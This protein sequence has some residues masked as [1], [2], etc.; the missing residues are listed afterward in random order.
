M[1]SKSSRNDSDISRLYKLKKGNNV[2]TDAVS[3]GTELRFGQPSPKSQT[4]RSPVSP[5]FRS[6]HLF[7]IRG[8]GDP[9][10]LLLPEQFIHNCNSSAME[11]HSQTLQR[12]SGSSNACVEGQTQLNLV[13]LGPEINQSRGAAII[14]HLKSDA[15]RSWVISKLLSQIKTP[16][17]G[18]MQSTATGGLIDGC[19]VL[20]GTLPCESHMAKYGPTSSPWNRGYTTEALM[21]INKLSAQNHVDKG[22]EVAFVADS[23]RVATQQNFKFPAKH[24]GSSTN[25]DGVGGTGCRSCLV[26]NEKSS[27]PYQLSGMPPDAFDP[28]NPI[29]HSG[30]IPYLG[31]SGH[32]DHGVLKS[33]SLRKDSGSVMPLQSVSMGFS[34]PTSTFISNTSPTLRTKEGSGIN[35]YFLDENLKALAFR[36]V[37]E[38]SNQGHGDAS[39]GTTQDQGRL[40]NSCIGKTQGFIVDPSS[41]KEHRHGLAVTNKQAASEVAM[42]VLQSGFTRWMNGDAE[43]TAPAAGKSE[44]SGGCIVPQ[45][46]LNAWLHINRQKSSPK[47]LPKLP[48][49]DV[50]YDCRKE[51]ARY[52][53]S[54][55]WKHLVVYKSGIHALGLYTPHF[56]SR[57]AMV[58][59]YVGEIVGLRVAD[60][61]ESEYQSGRKLQYKSACYFF[62]IDKEHIID[63]TRK[64]GVARFVNHSCLPNC[65]AKVISL[66]NEKKVVFFAERDIYP[67]EE[68]T[69]DYHFNHEDDGE[70]IP[71]FC[72][73][74]NC[75]RYLN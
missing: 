47:G 67:G 35:P 2:D 46:Q 56:I 23:L 63:A 43:N 66:R 71:C 37:I 14:E 20:P 72:N 34:A 24:M 8:H 18:R 26:V 27:H 62:R 53:Q 19:H 45:E 15:D 41:S 61:R 50:E 5:A 11:Y 64:G 22:K 32:L 58:V 39:F 31:L 38:V 48:V 12:A 3:S 25:C 73:S 7:D 1:K 9:Q 17:D 75:R 51:Y 10:K 68:I 4:S 13:N 60:K 40:H 57:G 30:K 74:K 29:N 33:T 36:H 44:G 28:R 16:I 55:C 69:Y 59:E 42:K 54:K 65:I 49:S 6:H 21:N 70:K 52:K